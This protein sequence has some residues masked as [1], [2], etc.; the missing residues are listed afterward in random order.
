[1]LRVDIQQLGWNQKVFEI[2]A[3][4]GTPYRMTT[5]FDLLLLEYP[6]PIFPR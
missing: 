3:P 4:D 6:Y 1:V 2:N 5:L